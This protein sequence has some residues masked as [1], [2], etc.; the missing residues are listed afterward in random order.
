[1]IERYV[2]EWDWSALSS[3]EGLPW[4]PDLLKLYLKRWDWRALSATNGLPWSLQL[5]ERFEDRWDWSQLSTNNAL[6][7]TEALIE[8]YADRWDWDGIE[9]HA[10]PELVPRWPESSVRAVMDRI[11]RPNPAEP[12]EIDPEILKSCVTRA[13]YHIEAGERAFTDYA[14]AMVEDLGDTVRPYLRGW[15]E[16]IRHYPRFDNGGMT[17]VG[18]MD[19]VVAESEKSFAETTLKSETPAK[20]EPGATNDRAELG[21]AD[22]ATKRP[23]GE[24]RNGDRRPTGTRDDRSLDG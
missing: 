15:Y 18:E 9:Y 23:A 16:G 6:P 2:E 11:L 24:G 1:L 13:C 14:R 17:P 7:W 4:I 8:R 20:A 22:Q 21:A 12:P 5:I 10:L 3:N 19:A